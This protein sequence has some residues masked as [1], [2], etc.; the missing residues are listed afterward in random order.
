MNRL[1]RYLLVGA[2]AGLFVMTAPA[3]QAGPIGFVYDSA[4][5]SGTV[6]ATNFQSFLN[7]RGYVTT[8]VPL[9]SLATTNFS[10]F[11]TIVLGND[12]GT[13]NLWDGLTGAAA[14]AAAGLI[15]SA[16]TPIVGIGEGGYAF[17]GVLGLPIGWPLGWHG[18][19]T[20]T[21]VVNPADLVFNSPNLIT[22]NGANPVQLF[23]SNTN[24]VSIY[25]PGATPAGLQLF[26]RDPTDAKHFTL[27]EYQSRF[28]LWGFSDDPTFMTAAGQN[29]FENV[30][31]SACVD[32]VGRPPCT[33]TTPVP[34]PVSLIL[35]GT[36]LACVGVRK[37]RRRQ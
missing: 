34:E 20:G 28:F 23:A 5:A 30:I 8:L 21:I 19:N 9:S 10:T 13:L 14:T 22:V 3:A 36:G 16:G 27:S 18:D 24:S 11:G 32:A 12:T 25:V 15:T 6:A 31:A 26:G 4:S 35:L 1:Y 2:C 33:P 7:G 37:A 17:Y 29:L